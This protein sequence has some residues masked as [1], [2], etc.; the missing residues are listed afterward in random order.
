M[1]EKGVGRSLIKKLIRSYPFFF[2]FTRI[3]LFKYS[4][5]YFGFPPQC[6][7]TLNKTIKTKNKMNKQKQINL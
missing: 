6:L 7:H 4:N 1:L 3:Q 2:C 5:K